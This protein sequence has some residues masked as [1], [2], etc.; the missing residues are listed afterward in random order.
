M[1]I[2]LFFGF[3]I[4]LKVEFWLLLFCRFIVCFIG[5]VCEFWVFGGFLFELCVFEGFIFEFCV[6]KGFVL[7]FCVFG[8]CVYELCFLGSFVFEYWDFGLR[9]M[10]SFI[11]LFC[12]FSIFFFDLEFWISVIVFV[13]S[14]G[15]VW[16]N[17][18][19]GC[20]YVLVIWLEFKILL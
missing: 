11:M 1:V 17:F 10:G 16:G 18:L 5:L 3:I 2:F 20:G 15:F 14:F 12:F 6:F 9:E 13:F 19:F 4:V 7:E 8:D